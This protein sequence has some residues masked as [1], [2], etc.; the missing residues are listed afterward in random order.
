MKPLSI[1]Y[2]RVGYNYNYYYY[3]DN[4]HKYIHINIWQMNHLQDV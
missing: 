3:N 4:K 2:L 1:R